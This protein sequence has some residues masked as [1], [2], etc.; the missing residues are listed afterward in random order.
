MQAVILAAGKSSRFYPFGNGKHKSTEVLLGVSI[1]EHTVSSI[2]K[3]GITDIIVVTDKN[4]H[5]RDSLQNAKG[6]GVHIRYVEQDDPQ[7]MGDAL[8]RAGEKLNDTFYVLHAHHF[9]F[10]QFAGDMLAKQDKEN[11]VLLAKATDKVDQFGVLKIDGDRVTDIIEKPSV[12]SQPSN[13]CVVGIYLL[14]KAFIATLESIPSEH[15][16]FESALAK[17]AREK[18]VRV[19]TTKKQTISLKYP[20]DLLSVNQYLL[21]DA[22]KSISD[23]AEVHKS[24]VISGKVII[25]DGVKVLEHATIKGPCYIGKNACIGTNATIRDFASINDGVVVGANMEIKNSV[26]M[27]NTT[28]HSGF[29]GDS[30]IGSTCKIAAF[31]CTG[32]VR[33]DRAPV[34]VKT[35]TGSID[36]SLRALGVCIGNNVNI[37]IRV[38]TM[39]GVLIGSNVVVGPSTT[40]FAHIPH[41]TRYYTKFQEVVT[42]DEGNKKLQRDKLK[43]MVLFDIDYTLFDTDIFKESN[44]ETYSLY[45][46][47]I[48]M[49]SGLQQIATIGIFSEGQQELQKAKLLKTKIHNHFPQEHLHIVAKK[50][51]TIGGILKKYADSTLFLVDDKLSMLQ[52]AKQQAPETV[53]IWIKRGPY[54]INQ[55][56]AIDFLPDATITTLAEVIAI[57]ANTN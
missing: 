55:A 29:I 36:T 8:L 28:T 51:E 49:L 33:F 42:E 23:K 10:D 40:V 5:V 7:G 35:T 39:P 18:T 57:V 26:I 44:L 16:S 22:K 32:N 25:E 41:S 27:R 54:A 38:S 15:Y 48:E 2:K 20:W 45:S 6:L 24:A 30:V 3:A 4:S 37:G 31:F 56:K 46:E 9:E 52:G 19:V 12:G 53:T 17:F 50:D 11:V 34:K 43:K 13:F 21:K 47:V 14:P 1:I